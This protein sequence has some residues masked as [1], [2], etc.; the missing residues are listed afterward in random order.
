MNVTSYSEQPLRLDVAPPKI[1]NTDDYISVVYPDPR[2]LENNLPGLL[3][4]GAITPGQQVTP[5]YFNEYPKVMIKKCFDKSGCKNYDYYFAPTYIRVNIHAD[6]LE[7][8]IVSAIIGQGLNYL[9]NYLLTRNPLKTVCPLANSGQYRY[10]THPEI[11][12]RRGE[13]GVFCIRV[14]DAVGNYWLTWKVIYNPYDVVEDV[15]QEA[16]T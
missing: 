6:D 7:T 5:Y 14:T 3:N 1:G 16:V 13:Q 12:S 15:V 4:R 11:R 10:N 8:G 9:Y 2:I